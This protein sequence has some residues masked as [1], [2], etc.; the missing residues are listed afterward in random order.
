MQGWAAAGTSHLPDGPQKVCLAVPRQASCA[1][2]PLRSAES[3]GEIR[4]ASSSLPSH[5][6]HCG[7]IVWLCCWHWVEAHLHRLLPC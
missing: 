4:P 7:V 5:G 1:G 3:G 2:W 6:P